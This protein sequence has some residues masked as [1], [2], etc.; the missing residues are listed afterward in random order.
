MAAVL[1]VNIDDFYEKYARRR[2]RGR[3]TFYELKEVKSQ[4]AVDEYDC[5]FLDRNTIP[6]KGICALYNSRPLQ[7]KTWPFWPELLEDKV[8]WE[9]AKKGKDGCPGLGQ[10][11]LIE[12]EEIERQKEETIKSYKFE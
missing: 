1:G 7:C 12:F 3:K 6:G 8:S 2:G 10:G 4:V 5:I 9:A 11:D